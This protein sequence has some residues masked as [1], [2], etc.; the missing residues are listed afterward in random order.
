MVTAIMP[1]VITTLTQSVIY[2]LP[3]K[4]CLLYASTGTFTVSNDSAM[5]TSTAITVDTNNQAELAAAF[6]RCTTS[7][8]S[9]VVKTY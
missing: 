1:G 4:R 8:I 7:D 6:I 9:V 2:A 5:V 3:P